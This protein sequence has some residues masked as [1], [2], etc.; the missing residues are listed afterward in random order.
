[1]WCISGTRDFTDYEA[2]KDMMATVL[3]KLK[4]GPKFIHVGDCTGIDA[5]AIRWAEEHGIEYKVHEAHWDKYGNAAGPARN[6]EMIALVDTLVAF[7]GPF[8]KGTRDAI[9]KARKKNLVIVTVNLQIRFE[10]T[11]GH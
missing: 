7:P 3:V 9:N 8:S 11:F 2:F 10:K 5:L 6:S 1:M 4:K